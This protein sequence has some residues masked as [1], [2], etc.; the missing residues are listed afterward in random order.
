MNENE[1]TTYQNVWDAAKAELRGKFITVNTY[2]LKKN[3]FKS[4]ILPSIIR[5]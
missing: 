2:I 5:N 3:D 4:T 1:S